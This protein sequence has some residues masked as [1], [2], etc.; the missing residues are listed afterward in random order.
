[1]DRAEDIIIES[2]SSIL[3]KP[4]SPSLNNDENAGSRGVT[5]SVTLDAS[6]TSIYATY[7]ET[8][9]EYSA[10]NKTTKQTSTINI[11]DLKG[12][13]G[14]KV[15][16][17]FDPS[18]KSSLQI[19]PLSKPMSDGYERL[20]SYASE[21]SVNTSSSKFGSWPHDFDSEDNLYQ[22]TATITSTVRSDSLENT[23]ASFEEDGDNSIHGKLDLL[24]QSIE[25]YGFDGEGKQDTKSF[26]S[27][28][29]V[30]YSTVKKIKKVSGTYDNDTYTQELQ[31]FPKMSSA[32]EEIDLGTSAIDDN[33]L[34]TSLDLHSRETETTRSEIIIDVQENEKES[35]KRSKLA[36]TERSEE[37]EITEKNKILSLK[38][39]KR[40]FNKDYQVKFTVDNEEKNKSDLKYSC[41]DGAMSTESTK[42][43]H[44]II[45]ECDVNFDTELNKEMEG[46]M[47]GMNMDP[48]KWF[49][50]DQSA[51]SDKPSDEWKVT[52]HDTAVFISL[53][54]E[55]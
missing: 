26:D 5:E 11:E 54:Y 41:K 45:Q 39:P 22:S 9:S 21:T 47:L 7:K 55:T 13:S 30:E 24:M 14:V 28:Q 16:T 32:K 2:P 12:D 3:V 37:T 1:M 17:I 29:E 33:A 20:E 38:K 53:A 49:E 15:G 36:S 6:G 34:T 43:S 27:K 50:L 51:D 4:A 31:M 35:Y 25:G 23:L 52:K 42:Q 18:R 48:S 8:K 19:T 46:M 44:H 40:K 10:T